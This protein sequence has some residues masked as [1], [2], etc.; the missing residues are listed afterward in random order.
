MIYLYF[1]NETNAV[2]T[3]TLLIRDNRARVL[4]I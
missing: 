3:V 4:R 1:W 2:Q